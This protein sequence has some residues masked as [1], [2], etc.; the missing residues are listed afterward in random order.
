MLLVHGLWGSG[1]ETW[2]ELPRRLFE[3]TDGPR[4]DV[5]TFGYGTGFWTRWFG[6]GDFDFHVDQLVGHL[7]SLASAYSAIFL[8]GHSLG[9]LL[10]EAA[11]VQYLQ[12]LATA[13]EETPGAVAALVFVA[14]PRAGSGW[15][16]PLLVGL[17][18]EFRTLK[19]LS[20]RSA[21]VDR[22][23]SSH[24]ERRN[25]VSDQAG[26]TSLPTY[27]ALG[28]RDR[29][30]SE[31]SAVFGVPDKQRLLLDATHSA[32]KMPDELDSEFVRWLHWVIASRLEVKEQARREL[33]H[34]HDHTD[35]LRSQDPPMVVAR[36]VGDATGLPWEELYNEVL[37]GA[38]SAEIEVRDQRDVLGDRLD[39]LI[40]V[41]DADL[42]VA[43]NPSVRASVQ[44][45]RAERDRRPSLSVGLSP[46]GMAFDAAESTLHDWLAAWP[47]AS[48]LYVRG[49]KDGAALREVLAR[50]L[51]LVIQRQ[52]RG[53][54]PD[55][56]A[57]RS[58]PSA[59]FHYDESR[60]GPLTWTLPG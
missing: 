4:M 24:I 35:Q 52:P 19:R 22:F 55:G 21:K 11:A 8:V 45:V 46:V 33:L 48:S 36:F 57:D 58:S 43:G 27:A 14:A 50:W 18:P 56:L 59:I 9:G 13:G 32:I 37:R 3:G 42:V 41:H 47:P 17:V 5:A 10:I 51:Q 60:K 16:S 25:V 49:A 6:Q 1:Y 20:S 12:D 31:F 54:I 30:V 2:G 23:F 7:R 38:T 26:I 29:L 15:A 53:A 40:A 44:E 28:G 34:L 39:V